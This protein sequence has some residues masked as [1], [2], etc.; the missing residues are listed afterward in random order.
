M[1]GASERHGMDLK[2]LRNRLFALSIVITLVIT[3]ALTV[4]EAVAISLIRSESETVVKC[5]S[6]PSR[7]SIHT[8]Y[9]EKSNLRIIQTEDGPTSIDGGLINLLSSYRTCSR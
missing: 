7:Y 3:G 6:L 1:A 5:Q 9:A 8:E 2:M 4:R